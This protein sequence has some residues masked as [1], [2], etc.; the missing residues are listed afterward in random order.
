MMTRGTYGL[1]LEG[2]EYAA[3]LA[4]HFAL[5]A[6]VRPVLRDTLLWHLTMSE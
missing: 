2:E 3:P 1:I 6:L 5:K 4:L